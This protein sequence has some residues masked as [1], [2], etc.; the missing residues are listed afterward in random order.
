MRHLIV[1]ISC[2]APVL[3]H[4]QEPA[5]QRPATEVLFDGKTLNGW[6]GDPAVWSVRDGCIVGS[7]VDA[8][9][10]ANTFLV[11]DAR[12]P[13]DFV[14]SAMV[15]LE[16]DNNSGVQY[17]SRELEPGA[18][19]VGGYQCD[20]HGKPEYQ[21][22]L[23]DEQGAGIV[24]QHGQFV[25]W[26]DSGRS[27]VGT[28]SRPRDIDV[29]SW[30]RL[31]IIACG[32]LVWHLVDGRVVTA[33]KDERADAPRQGVIAL[34]V[35]TGAPMTVW[36]KDLE[37]CKYPSAEVMKQDVAVPDAV[38]ALLR[39]EA[40]RG[41]A[42]KGLVPQ[43][44]WD[45]AAADE[46]E[47]F[48]RRAFTLAKAPA[49]ARFTVSCDNHCRLYVN[50]EKVGQGDEWE[51]PVSVDVQKALKVGDNVIAV[52]GWNDRGPAA[53]A[54]RL[55]WQ[56]DG[57]DNELVS[58]ATW[59][60]S[61]DDPDG[62][63]TP[64]FA[65]QGWQPVRVL[66][67]MGAKDADWTRVHG[68]EAL[69]SLVDA[70][71]PQVA[72][73]ETGVEWPGHDGEAPQVLRLLSVPRS[74]GS[75]VSLGADPK[76]RLYASD[77]RRGL[78]RIVPA[79]GLGEL[80][81]VERV[82]VDIGGCH[83]FLW[84]RDALYAVV[85]GKESGLYRLTDTN[86]DDV[87][88]RVEKL[89]AL[90]GEGEHGPHSVVV[91]P[92]GE[93]LLV[94]CGNQTKLPKLAASRV[95]TNW[96]EDRLLPR[97]DEPNPY[98]EGHS[99]PGGW[100]CQVDP[101]GKRWELLCCGFRNPFDLVVGPR[102]RIVTYD[103]DME[104][105]MGLPWY[106][107][108][109]LLE[110]QS[111]VDYGW[112][113]ASAKWPDDYPDA[114][115]A[116]VD[117]G[118]GSPTGMAVIDSGRSFNIVAL[119][120]TFGTV[121]VNGRPWLTGAPLP[122]ADVCVVG[123][124][125]YLVTGGRGLPTRLLCVPLRGAPHPDWPVNWLAIPG[126]PQWREQEKR[127]VQELLADASSASMT[128]M[129]VG[130]FVDLRIAVERLP[131]ASWRDKALAFAGEPEP[132]KVGPGMSLALLLALARQGNQD[133]LQPVLDAS[134]RVS[135]ASPNRWGPR[136]R[137]PEGFPRLPPDE[138]IAWLRVHALALMRLGPANDAQRAAIAAR[139][140]P[141]FPANDE[142]VDADLAELL[143]YVDAPGFLDKAVPM[144]SP[145]RPSP[146]PPWADITKRNATYGGVIDAMSK[147]MPPIGQIAIANALRTV[148]HGWT[149]DQRRTFFT[150]LAEARKRK[151]GSSYDG[152]IKK[153]I[154]AGWAT[155][156]PAEQEALAEMVGKAKADAPKFRATPPKGPGR[157]WQVA[158][159]D[160][161]TRD[162]LQGRDVRAG[163]NLFHA[164]GCA[165]CHYFAGEGGNHGPDLTSLAN[166]F[167]ARDVLES[168]LEPSNVISDQYSG[169]VLTRKDGSAIFGSVKKGFHGDTEVY[170]VVPA[171]AEA[172]LVR[173]PVA[174]VAKVEPSKLSPMPKDLVDNLSADELR[175]LL[176]FLLSRGQGLGS[177]K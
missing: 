156:T 136:S 176:A 112:R 139:L 43:W 71:A 152:Y 101:D 48:F 77:Q 137:L 1:A 47:L 36:W 161:L 44:L 14:W 168:I 131:V 151:G 103:A 37:L 8:P 111:G 171:V 26:R 126:A 146:A 45:A 108:T 170:E 60:C 23:Y 3:A 28:L 20:L 134:S 120:W 7:T 39:Q 148:K 32:D 16:G 95:P 58:D 17:R 87:L 18:F 140:L 83:G 78:Y 90:D 19:R 46:E 167:T 132:A 29:S 21:A 135:V 91:A 72:V 118:P 82:P 150:F 164:V 34:Q 68:E 52:H 31:T 25:L 133:D 116:I 89:T 81:K 165:S 127:S 41:D 173:V 177:G 149:L 153:I 50:G 10:K 5:S 114:P 129:W 64:G 94:L 84:F 107:P 62:W 128:S 130:D 75:W 35:H 6:R 175:N 106:R 104:W 121:Y 105:D 40:L 162:G 115:R 102:G 96:A 33:V 169:S 125:L 157:D 143:A 92:D 15:R 98:W 159:A 66:A 30:H 79:S 93:N 138:R 142:R 73:V 69:G 123:E 166:K 12:Q 124:M 42:P 24:A 9:I 145:L 122:L 4:E 163:H 113:I 27:V 59:L 56:L 74:L 100:V 110:V 80:T 119:D 141:L 51:S 174:D 11:L 76:G 61:S 160:G 117:L 97:I 57:K 70:N 53:M 155:C 172:A 2:C 22:M 54:A 38:R 158:D 109:R 49:S 85:N 13:G 63:N 88:D 55:S 147:N 99:P 65:A 86:A 154:D 67:A 144:L